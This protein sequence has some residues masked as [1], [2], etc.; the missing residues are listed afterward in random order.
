LCEL[1]VLVLGGLCGLLLLLESWA[2][3]GDTRGHVIGA[4]L[5]VFQLL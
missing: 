1:L 2:E 5:L 3:V 4:L